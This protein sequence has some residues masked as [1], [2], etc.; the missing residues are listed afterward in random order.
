MGW[1]RSV[2]G[3]AGGCFRTGF[4]GFPGLKPEGFPGV[5]G[6]F[7]QRDGRRNIWEFPQKRTLCRGFPPQLLA[8]N[9]ILK[10]HFEVPG[11]D[12]RGS[13]RCVG[14]REA[15]L[16]EFYR[17]RVLQNNSECSDIGPAPC[18][19]P[20]QMEVEIYQARTLQY[21]S[22]CSDMAG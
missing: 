1:A 21:E 6:H 16:L 15:T 5:S 14:W 18:N 12:P 17:A 3:W 10:G 20:Y 4:Q 8:T 7:W 9:I 11:F 22:E 2:V 13:L 19:P